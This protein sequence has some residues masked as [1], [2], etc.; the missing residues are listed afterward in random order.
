MSDEHSEPAI[1]P[2]VLTVKPPVEPLALTAAPLPVASSGPQ[3]QRPVQMSAASASCAMRGDPSPRIIMVTLLHPPFGE[4]SV[5]VPAAVS[6]DP[7]S[8]QVPGPASAAHVPECHVIVFK[9]KI[10]L[11]A[12]VTGRLDIALSGGNDSAMRSASLGRG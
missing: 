11:D 8:R 9:R 3:A 7:A 6:F 12:G 2:P 5:H 4:A 1:E 10:C